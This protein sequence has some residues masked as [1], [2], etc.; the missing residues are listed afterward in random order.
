MASRRG[1]VKTTSEI[2]GMAYIGGRGT[3]AIQ[4]PLDSPSFSTISNPAFTEG[5]IKP[6]GVFFT[7]MQSMY[8]IKKKEF[9]L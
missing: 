1:S 4:K 8:I 6:V 5:Y 2:A 3:Y 9:M 7:T